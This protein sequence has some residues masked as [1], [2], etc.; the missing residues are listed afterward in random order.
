MHSHKSNELAL[1]L[2]ERPA[3][4]PLYAKVAGCVEPGEH[5]VMER[6]TVLRAAARQILVEPQAALATAKS[7]ESERYC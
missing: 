6:V 1:R 4:D 5:L 3:L 7:T 2:I